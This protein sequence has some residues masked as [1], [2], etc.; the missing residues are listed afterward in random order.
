M[1]LPTQQALPSALTAA[2]TM[3]LEA[4][5]VQSADAADVVAVALSE[6]RAGNYT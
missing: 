3:A 6:A 4:L 5:E 1:L 2:I